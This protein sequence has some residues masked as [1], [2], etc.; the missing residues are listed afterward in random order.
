MR[1]VLL[2]SLLVSSLPAVARSQSLLDGPRVTPGA[3]RTPS[4]VEA[5]SER[6]LRALIVFSPPAAADDLDGGLQARRLDDHLRLGR[7]G[8]VGARSV[9]FGLGAFSGAIGLT[10]HAPPPF[11]RLFDGQVHLGPAILDGSAMGA[12]LGGRF[13]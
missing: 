12:A 11:A 5:H 2:A 13:R 7:S 8:E 9:G 6:V 4:Y 3:T 10:A 1:C